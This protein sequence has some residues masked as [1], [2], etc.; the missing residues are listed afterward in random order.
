MWL[1]GVGGFEMRSKMWWPP[2]RSDSVLGQGKV[3]GFDPSAEEELGPK[4]WRG[5]GWLTP[6]VEIQ[7]ELR[8]RSVVLEMEADSDGF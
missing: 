4:A 7:L 6:S 8:L 1:T 5:Q 3:A 2:D